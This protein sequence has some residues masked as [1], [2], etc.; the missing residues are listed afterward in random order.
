MK[1]P[2]IDGLAEALGDLAV[3]DHPLGPLTTYRV[4]GPAALFADVPDDAA[5]MKLAGAV[6]Q[7]GGGTGDEGV[8]VLVIG[9][10]SNILVSERGFRGLAVH[11]GAGFG[12]VEIRSADSGGPSVVAGGAVDLPTL[13]RRTVAAG[14]AGL[15]WAV[16]VPGSLGGAVRM[17]AGGHG[18]ETADVLARCVVVDVSTGRRRTVSPSALDLSYRHSSLRDAEIVVAAELRLRRGDP[19]EGREALAAIVRWRRENQP[20]GSNAGSVFTNPPGGSAGRLIEACG[21]KGHRVGSAAVSEKHANFIQC[22]D[23]GSADDVARLVAEVRARV[24]EQTGVVLA[25]EVRM[26]GF[27]DAGDLAP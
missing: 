23:G 5:L 14:L 3:R 25:V 4:G 2:A 15:E 20:G 8:A 13:A 24:A 26:V 7:S 17:N 12:D 16:G 1:G 6:A 21:L 18:S 27:P 10:G 11:L 22:D 9:R 19:A